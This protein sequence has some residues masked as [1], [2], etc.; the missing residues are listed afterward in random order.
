M[1]EKNINHKHVC[2]VTYTAL[3]IAKLFSEKHN[4]SMLSCCNVSNWE[5]TTNMIEGDFSAG[6]SCLIIKD[7]IASG[8]SILETAI[9]LRSEG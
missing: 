7:I 4:K 1:K 9:N 2:D 5:N 8:T 3:P 6:D